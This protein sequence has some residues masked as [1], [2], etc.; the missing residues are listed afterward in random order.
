MAETQ[1]VIGRGKV[2]FDRFVSPNNLTPTGE[3]YLGN[4][5]TLTITQAG[6]KLDHYG[7]DEGLKEKDRSVTIQNDMTGKMTTDNIDPENMALF[8]LGENAPLTVAAAPAL[9]ETLI[10]RPGLSYQLGESDDEPSGKRSLANFGA[11]LSAAGH[12]NVLAGSLVFNGETGRIDVADNPQDIDA[13]GTSVDVTYDQAGYSR[14]AV[15]AEGQ[16]IF[17]R[18]RFIADN[19]VGLNQ[20]FFAPYAQLTSDG[21]YAWKGDDWQAMGFNI[22]LL[23]LSTRAKLYID[24]RPVIA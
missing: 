20:D 4:T 8:W 19:P 10:L 23:K 18:L 13:A 7:S 24:G 5:P 17:G 2:Y 16:Q 3:R 12:A 14:T 1:L 21:D 11:K 15:I 6:T 22:E 9:T